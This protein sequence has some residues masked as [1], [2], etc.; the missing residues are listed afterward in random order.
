[1]SKEKIVFDN[2]T[3][4]KTLEDN[5]KT[6][7]ELESQGV[8]ISK[9][10]AGQ[11]V[12]IKPE[13]KFEDLVW[14][15]IAFHTDAV[16]QKETQYIIKGE[17]LEVDRKLQN[18]LQSLIKPCILVPYQDNGGNESIWIVKQPAKG[19]SSM[20]SH[21][22]SIKAVKGMLDGWRMVWFKNLK[23]GY[24]CEK[25][26]DQDAFE[27]YPFSDFTQSELINFAFDDDIV[28]SM[29][30]DLIKDFKGKKNR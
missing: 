5:N 16:S 8:S 15:N 21:S 11:Y 20:T 12:R 9:P 17:S 23:V 1:M 22:S 24:C 30:H 27:D 14:V 18:I 13:T 7:G 6:L 2:A 28:T 19:Q 10:V 3:T 26:E 4:Q 25:P 29:D